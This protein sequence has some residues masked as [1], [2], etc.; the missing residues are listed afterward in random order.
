MERALALLLLAL[1]AASPST[2]APVAKTPAVR[3]EGAAE[4][5]DR[6]PRALATA[7]DVESLCAALEPAERLRAKGDAVAKGEA[8]RQHDLARDRAITGRYE[9]VVPATKLPF[10]PYDAAEERLA[11]TDPSQL[12]VAGGAARLWP[13][14]ERGLPVEADPAAARRILQAQRTGRLE[15]RLVFDLPDDTVCGATP[16][17]KRYTLSVEPVAWRWLDG[18]AVLGRGGA[19]ADRPLYTASQGAKPRIHVGAPVSGG[20][21]ARRHV[22]AHAYDLEA[23][24]TQALKRDPSLDGVIVAELGGATPAIA[25]DSVG[26]SGL[27][28]CVRSALRGVPA[29]AARA[30]V[31]IRFVLEPPAPP[32]AAQGTGSAQGR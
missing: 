25:A 15:L 10:A 9:V 8:E 22:L 7:A 12:P 5:A 16:R 24:Y 27:A 14:E 21:D 32:A 18:E 3:S 6:P 19:G 11:L 30:A 2:P 23:C 13:T 31:P 28:S 4:D 20:A 1:T 17:A 29:E 26:D